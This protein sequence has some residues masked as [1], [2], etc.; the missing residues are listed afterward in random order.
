MA[1]PEEPVGFEESPRIE[2]VLADTVCYNQTH[3]SCRP[4]LELQ[5]PNFQ[6]L[7]ASQFDDG[8]ISPTRII[9]IQNVTA[10]GYSGN[11]N[12]SSLLWSNQTSLEPLPSPL[13]E[14][15]SGAFTPLSPSEIQE[16]YAAVMPTNSQGYELSDSPSSPEPEGTSRSATQI[17]ESKTRKKGKRNAKRKL[18]NSKEAAK[19][20]ATH[21]VIEKRYRSN[22]NSKIAELRDS[23]PSLCAVEQNKAEGESAEDEF[24]G[25]SRPTKVNKVS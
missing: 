17:L 2:D 1:S 12:S 19:E 8:A 23:V 13:I 4:K 18:S 16:L 14:Q 24:S 21:N 15:S 3:P 9:P 10:T 22:L 7:P 20:R 25:Y 5:L 6:G 11:T